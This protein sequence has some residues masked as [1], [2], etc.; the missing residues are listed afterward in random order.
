MWNMAGQ[1]LDIGGF[2]RGISMIALTLAY[3]RRRV[4]GAL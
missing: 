3:T 1:Y 4:G 2:H